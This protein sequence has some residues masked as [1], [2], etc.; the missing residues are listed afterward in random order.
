MLKTLKYIFATILV[1]GLVMTSA[2]FTLLLYLK[3]TDQEFLIGSNPDDMRQ[4]VAILTENKDDYNESDN[5]DQK[6]KKSS[7]RP[8]LTHLSF[9]S[10]PNFITDVKLQH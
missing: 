9:F 3:I 6:K 10:Y 8:L 7:N 4:S 1:I 5:V 2:F